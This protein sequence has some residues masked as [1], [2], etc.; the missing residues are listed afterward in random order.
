M[1]DD[2]DKII[3]V[4]CNGEIYNHK[5]LSQF[6]DIDLQSGSDCEIIYPLYQKI[7]TKIF[8][9]LDSESA[10][11]I[12]EFHKTTKEV[13]FIVSRDTFGIRPLFVRQSENTICFSSERKGLDNLKKK[14]KTFQFPP[15]C[16]LE[17]SSLDDFGELKFTEYF[18]ISKIQS[19]ITN[20]E[21]ALK[22]IHD[23]LIDSVKSRMMC[24]R[25]FA[26][27]LSGGLDS[28]LITA[29]AQRILKE[30]GKILKTFC[31]AMDEN[32]PDA[33]AAKIVAAFC[34]TFHTTI[35]IP[36]IVW[37]LTVLYDIIKKDKSIAD[38]LNKIY[39]CNIDDII[40]EWDIDKSIIEVI[41]S[42]DIT[43][44]RASTGQYLVSK[45]IAKHHPDIKVLLIGDGSDELTGGYIYMLKAPSHEDFIDEIFKLLNDIHYFDVLRSDR[46]IASN[47]QEAR[48]PFLRKQFVSAYLSIDVKLRMPNSGIEKELLRDAFK[49]SELLPMEILYRTKEAFSD[50][51][52]TQK[53]SWYTILKEI[54]D[55][56]FSNTY[57][58]NNEYKHNKPPTKES[59]YYRTIYTELFDDDDDENKIIPRFWL[60]NWSGNIQEPSARVLAHYN[61]N[62]NV[63]VNL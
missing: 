25:E 22:L 56:I 19:V 45:W 5:S 14:S 60:P 43:T 34:K 57:F 55:Q 17:F 59:L 10:I 36:E 32:S 27:L 12:C 13:K 52:S 49:E 51:V 44:V 37:I 23:E 35:I 1:Y 31:I 15:R 58:E 16:F 41:E 20:R 50:G 7:G 2:E 62:S 40:E 53:R 33:R 26:C 48:V 28:S 46:G 18:N 61:P 30:R 24:D 3:H 6:Y 47:G 4:I 11:I 42:Y 39:N 63:S 8:E 9:E 21:Q 54:F 38:L 29:I